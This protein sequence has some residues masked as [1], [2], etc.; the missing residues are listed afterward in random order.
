MR[1]SIL[2]LY[3]N[4]SSSKQCLVIVDTHCPGFTFYK[5]AHGLFKQY[6]ENVSHY[7]FDTTDSCKLIR[8]PSLIDS[9]I[10]SDG[11]PQIA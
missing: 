8:E 2:A 10:V 11:C 1:L 3:T 7:V 4:K 5:I 6:V 9:Y